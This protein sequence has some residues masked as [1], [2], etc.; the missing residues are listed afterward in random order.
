MNDDSGNNPVVTGREQVLRPLSY[1]QLN[2]VP[3][4]FDGT[5]GT[6]AHVSVIANLRQVLCLDE[7]RPNPKLQDSRRS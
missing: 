1:K 3:V 6:G 5:F 7:P 2:R 4:D